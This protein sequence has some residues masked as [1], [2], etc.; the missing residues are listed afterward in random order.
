MAQPRLLLI[1]DE[2]ALADFL[3][4]AARESGFEPVITSED[5]QFRDEFLAN[6]PN[7]VALDLGMPGMDGVATIGHICRTYPTV[8]L[9]VLS[10]ADPAS[11]AEQALRAGAAGFIPKTAVSKLLVQAIRLVLAGGQYVPPQVLHDLGTST[12]WKTPE[13]AAAPA[14]PPTPPPATPASPWRLD[15]LS[16]RQRE[17]FELLATGLSN[18]AIARKLDVTEGT[19]KSHVAAIFDV[20]HV[21]NRV[22][23]VAE[24]RRLVEAQRHTR[25]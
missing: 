7:M 24:A 18:K 25:G 22:S 14:A 10:G 12:A 19:V 21:H 17:V 23:A 4:N 11:A 13:T 16:G 9:I 6:P 5:R 2:P 15:M 8:P 3:A 1:D 20:L